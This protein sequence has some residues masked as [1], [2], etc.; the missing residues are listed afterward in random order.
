MTFEQ[1]LFVVCE[2]PDFIRMLQTVTLLPMNSA[3]GSCSPSV[4]IVPAMLSFSRMGRKS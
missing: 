2:S 1:L 4:R 3:T